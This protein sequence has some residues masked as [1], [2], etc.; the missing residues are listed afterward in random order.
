[1][2]ESTRFGLMAVFAVSGSMVFLVHQVH[3]RLLS[4]FMKKFE[5]EM[6]GVLY[7]HHRHKNFS[8]SEKHHAKKKVRFAKEV[9]E[10][11]LKEK[12]YCRNVNKGQQGKGVGDVLVQTKGCGPELEDTMP[13]NRA[14]LYRGIM[15]YRTL[16]G[17][18]LHF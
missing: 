1:M 12:G 18:Q 14:V 13:P 9:M 17:A 5:F 16:K 7:S 4:N 10:F 6:S 8:A 2:E 3:K 11:P 15:Q